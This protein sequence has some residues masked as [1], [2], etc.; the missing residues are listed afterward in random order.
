MFSLIKFDR[1]ISELRNLNAPIVCQKLIIINTA[2][3]FLLFHEA[4]MLLYNYLLKALFYLLKKEISRTLYTHL[5]GYYII[6]LSFLIFLTFFY[7]NLAMSESDTTILMSN[8]TILDNVTI[9]T[10]TEIGSLFAVV[11]PL[12]GLLWFATIAACFA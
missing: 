8:D 10:T 6:T 3:N 9:L 11:S 7:S 4:F 12:I 5:H 2:H 1:K